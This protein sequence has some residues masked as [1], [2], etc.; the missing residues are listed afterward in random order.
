MRVFAFQKVDIPYVDKNPVRIAIL[1]KRFEDEAFYRSIEI[2]ISATKT[3]AMAPFVVFS[4]MFG[5]KK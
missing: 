5:C 3:N 4:K 1:L 2:K